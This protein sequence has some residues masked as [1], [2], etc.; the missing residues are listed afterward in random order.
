MELFK[1]AIDLKALTFR[2]IKFYMINSS[3]SKYEDN[4]KFCEERY[5]IAKKVS[6]NYI[7]KY[8]QAFSNILESKGNVKLYKFSTYKERI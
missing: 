4:I 8:K 6:K 2:K 1:K 5:R 3:N 7:S